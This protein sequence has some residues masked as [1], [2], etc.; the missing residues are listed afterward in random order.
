MV[1]ERNLR[2]LQRTPAE[3]ASGDQP[4]GGP[5]KIIS[6]GLLAAA[7]AGMS[8]ATYARDRIDVGFYVG[9]PA[10]AYAPPPA[11]YYV[12]P[13]APVYYTEYYAGPP[14]TYYYPPAWGARYHYRDRFYRDHDHGR[15]HE[16]GGYRR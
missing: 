8:A 13:P 10:Y 14:V 3:T 2:D 15:G 12:P 6:I 1:A 4:E 7:L 5:M 11:T 9:T 16:H